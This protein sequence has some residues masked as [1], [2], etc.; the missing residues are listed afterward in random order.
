MSIESRNIVAKGKSV[1]KINQSII[2]ERNKM[3]LNQST[4]VLEDLKN[5]TPNTLGKYNR[6][7][8]AYVDCISIKP[9][10]NFI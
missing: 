10:L 9:L 4:R 7:R 6:S 5:L 2:A 3:C 1:S 8:N